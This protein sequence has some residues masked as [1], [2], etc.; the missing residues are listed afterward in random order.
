[1]PLAAIKD[2]VLESA[3]VSPLQR[4]EFF[5]GSRGEAPPT[6]RLIP[7]GSPVEVPS[8]KRTRKTAKSAES[9]FGASE[10]CRLGG[11]SVMKAT[12]PISNSLCCYNF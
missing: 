2:C 12:H 1:M 6:K 7:R 5:S 11:E 9:G 8:A 3:G 10:L 4:Y